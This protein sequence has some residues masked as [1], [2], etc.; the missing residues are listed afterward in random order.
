MGAALARCPN[1][2]LQR[3]SPVFYLSYALS[4]LRRRKGRTILTALGLA[5]GVALVVVVNALSTG[6]KDAQANVLKP[7][8]GVGTDMTVTR[9]LVLSTSGG[10]PFANLTPA[11][12]SQLRK[13]AGGQ[14]VGFRNIAKPGKKFSVDRFGFSSQLTFPQSTVTKIKG[15]KDVAAASGSLSLNDT[16]ISGTIP[17][18]SATTSPGTDGTGNGGFGGGGFGGG[19]FGGNGTGGART[20]GG[21]FFGGPNGINFTSMSVNGID[22]TTPSLAPVT[23][24]QITTGRYFKSSGDAYAAVLSTSY[25]DT[26][27]LKV[28]KTI[29]LDGKTFTI[30]GLAT[31]PLGG[32]ASDV[33]V[34]LPTLQKLAGDKGVVN[35]MAVEATTGS[36]VTTVQ[37]EV[38]TT[39]SGAQVTTATALA[40]RIGGSLKDA[41]NLSTTLGVA[42][43]IVG[44][45][46]AVLIALLLTLSSV[47]KRTREI[48]TLKAIGWSQALVVRQISF[49]ALV[50]GL[51]G[52]IAG[53]ILG[54]IAAAVVTAM[55]I[56]LQATITPA[57]ASTPFGF[58]RFGGG[59]PFG[60]AGQAASAAST[61]V[62]INAP[63]DTAL[64]LIAV[65]L[66]A[67]AGLIAGAIGGMRAGALRPASALRTVE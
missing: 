6:L 25:A 16:H 31:A 9:P 36:A 12:R 52:G 5:V 35:T 22:T 34:E 43:E 27:N 30:I 29:T 56:P 38:K 41:K 59:G 64:I 13:E 15:L 40:S 37:N 44:L 24:S 49:E 39:L 46:A 28:G 23:P 3:G 48:G 4:E 61:T 19:G 10:N 47:A 57:A 54:F 63:V 17:K 7:L 55:R 32:S 58:G 20:P 45:L 11:Q 18:R 60:Q 66:A 2:V 62:H 1:I 14:R 53:A 33:Y 42:L 21:G 50:Q 51:L 26:N 65:A 67:L 8:T